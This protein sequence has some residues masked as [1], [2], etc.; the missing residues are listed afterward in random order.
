[1]PFSEALKL[2]RRR[3]LAAKR[4]RPVLSVPR[5][6]IRARRPREQLMV[7]ERPV[8]RHKTSQP[9][10]TVSECAQRYL[11]VLENPFKIID[12]CL[13]DSIPFPTKRSWYWSKGTFSTSST[14]GVGY[15]CVCPMFVGFNNIVAGWYST[16]LFA[17]TTITTSAGTGIVTAASNSP[18]STATVGANFSHRLVA[19]GLRIKYAG[20]ELN[21]G[22]NMIGMESPAHINTSGMSSATIQ[23]FEN[24]KTVAVDSRR[25]WA[26][27]VHHPANEPEMQFIPVNGET[28][29]LDNYYLCFLVNAPSAT[30]SIAFDFEIQALF[31]EVGLSV[32][33]ALPSHADVAGMGLVHTVTSSTVHRQ[34]QSGDR[35]S[36]VSRIFSAIKKNAPSLLTGIKDVIDVGKKAAPY[37]KDILELF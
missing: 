21:L 13:P 31:E 9:V 30:T 37:V 34:P 20:T 36:I 1:M 17:G 12:A 14:T 18:Y 11:S 24:S 3:L 16:A 25:E 33:G 32:G 4:K 26:S 8:A 10:V 7:R 35:S 6:V 23:T 28:G 2:R 5:S 29:T 22:G 19:A 27:V 15:I